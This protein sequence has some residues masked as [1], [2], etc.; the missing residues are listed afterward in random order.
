MDDRLIH[1]FPGH[2]K[3][4]ISVAFSR[5]GRRLASGS[6]GGRVRLWDA[7]A[8]GE[9]LTTFPESRDARHPVTAMAFGPDDG[10]L[11]TASFERRVDVWDTTTGGLL[12]SLPHSRLVLGAAFSPDGRRLASAGED[13]TVRVWDATTGREVLVLGGHTQPSQG[14]AFSPDGLRL[15]SG[16]WDGTIRI[17]D[18]T[19]LRGDKPQEEFT[20]SEGANEVWTMAVSPDGRSVASAGLGGGRVKVWDVEPRRFIEFPSGRQMVFSVAWH[21]RG[22]RIAIACWD[23]RRVFAVKVW[24]PRTNEACPEITFAMETY[25][26]AFSPDGD[27]LVTGNA[28]GAVQVWNARTGDPVGNGKLGTH[29]RQVLG[30]VF[31]RDRRYLASASANGEIKVWDATRLG[32][33]QKPLRTFQGRVGI[34]QMMPAFSPD[35]QRLVAGGK[36]NTVKIWDVQTSQEL[37]SLQGHSGDVWATAF[38]PDLEGWW[39]ASAGEDS[40]VKIWDSRSGELIRNFRGH[41][42]IVSSL[43]FSPDGGRLYSGSRDKT[44]K[45]WNMTELNSGPGR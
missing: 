3:R 36:E 45:A 15:A 39:V 6:W 33:E 32:E 21:P 1:A 13:K 26:V 10:W 43:T 30:V 17:W 7:E 5:D 44:V 22:D 18:A 37:R 28:N 40:T 29:G 42:G 12:R 8:G 38:S 2:E 27:Y 25:A 16:S 23:E 24:G 11:A 9:P 31:S 4:A 14:V 20:L 35:G 34:G 41:F 19:P